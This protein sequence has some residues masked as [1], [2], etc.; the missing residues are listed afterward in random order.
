MA[1]DAN[2]KARVRPRH[3]DGPAWLLLVVERNPRQ[4]AGSEVLC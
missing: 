3:F 2:T 4:V 1:A